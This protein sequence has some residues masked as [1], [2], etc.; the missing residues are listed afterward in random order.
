MLPFLRSDA[1]PLAGREASLVPPLHFRPL[2]APTHIRWRP[3][4]STPPKGDTF[5]QRL[6]LKY[7]ARIM[8]KL[9]G[10]FPR[11]VFG[12][13]IHF[14]DDQKART[15]QPDAVVF[16]EKDIFVFEVKYTHCP[17]AWWQLEK[18]Y[19]P[20]L[21]LLHHS[22]PVSCVE[23]CRSYDPATPFPCPTTLIE[24]IVSWTSQ[25][26]PDFGVL[27]WRV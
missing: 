8:E 7:E 23:I 22:R 15:C 24:D 3:R 25:A 9:Q 2:V 16:F 11:I 13:Y 10:L 12:P 4:P 27:Q 5:S 1:I 20:L 6:G 17:E 19:A 18:L 21:R 14:L 26:R